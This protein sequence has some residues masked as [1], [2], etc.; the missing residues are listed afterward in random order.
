MS[1]EEPSEDNGGGIITTE[2]TFWCALCSHWEQIGTENR[3][4]GAIK[5]ARKSGWKLVDGKWQC[6]RHAKEK[7]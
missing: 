4:A 1:D 2:W 5:A 7:A 3:R 6:R